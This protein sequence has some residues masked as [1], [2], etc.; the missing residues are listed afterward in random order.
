[1]MIDIVMIFVV[2]F[3]VKHTQKTQTDLF[4]DFFVGFMTTFRLLFLYRETLLTDKINIGIFIII[5]DV[6]IYIFFVC[7][8]IKVVK[9]R[10]SL[11]VCVTE[12]FYES[13]FF[14]RLWSVRKDMLFKYRRLVT[15]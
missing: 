2:T 8:N 14:T 4:K 3:V 7:K 12:Q 9:L 13:I 1:M 10:R 6:I 15:D 5:C 11:F